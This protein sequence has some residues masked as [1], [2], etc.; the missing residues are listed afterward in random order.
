MDKPNLVVLWAT[1]KLRGLSWLH[2]GY[3]VRYRDSVRHRRSVGVDPKE[4]RNDETA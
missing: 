1:R 2:F 3:K 4:G